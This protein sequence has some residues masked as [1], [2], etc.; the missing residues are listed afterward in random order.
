VAV[1]CVG[2]E[3]SIRTAIAATRKGG[4]VTLVGN[5]A[6]QVGFPLQEVVTRQVRVQGSCASCGEYPA[7]IELLSRGAIRVDALITAV[8]PLTEGVTWFDRLYRRE[9]NLMKVILRP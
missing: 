1:E 2:A 8:A 5:M 3:A 7:V 4:M 6:P 9:P